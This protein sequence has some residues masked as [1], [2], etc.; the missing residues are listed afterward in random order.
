MSSMDL[1]CQRSPV[2]SMYKA[3]NSGTLEYAHRLIIIEYRLGF[4]YEAGKQETLVA[5]IYGFDSFSPKQIAVS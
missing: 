4:G 3:P 2:C 5:D 1:L